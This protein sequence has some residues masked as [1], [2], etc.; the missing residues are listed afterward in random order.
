MD[1]TKKTTK[2][3][4]KHRDKMLKANWGKTRRG[5]QKKTERRIEGDNNK[6]NDNW[7][8]WDI[9]TEWQMIETRKRGRGRQKN[10]NE[11]NK[12]RNDKRNK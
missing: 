4:N 8:G 6:K 7:G 1:N 10:L 9:W 12:G 5:V 2:Q 11:I 3:T